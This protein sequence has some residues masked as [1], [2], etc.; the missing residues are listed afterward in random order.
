M[1]LQLIF[2]LETNA[3]CRSDWI[4]IKSTL[5]RFCSTQL[6]KV[7]LSEVYMDGKKKYKGSRINTKIK[8]LKSQY[9]VA[10]SNNESKVIFCFDLDDYDKCKEEA[11]FVEETCLYCQKNSFYYVWFCKDIE[12]VYLK[13]RIS[14]KEKKKESEKFK[15]KKLIHSIEKK[16]LMQATQKSKYKRGT[17]NL[18]SVLEEVGLSIS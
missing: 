1:G 14:D 3:G 11:D 12:E 18:L 6:S 8:Q 4:Y 10:C 9:S 16:E 2:V 5:E 17:S 15:R 7:K 13:K